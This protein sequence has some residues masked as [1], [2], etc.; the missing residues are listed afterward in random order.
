MLENLRHYR[1]TTYRQLMRL[2]VD[3]ATGGDLHEHVRAT[4]GL[5]DREFAA[6]KANVHSAAAILR[7]DCKAG[8][9]RFDVEPE[10]FMLTGRVTE[11][12]LDCE[13]P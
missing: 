8:R 4:F 3:F 11:Q 6:I 12:R 5:S 13:R 10:E 2:D 1:A 9:L 7:E